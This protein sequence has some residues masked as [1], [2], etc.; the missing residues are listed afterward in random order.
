MEL[1]D[2]LSVLGVDALVHDGQFVHGVAS[3]CINSRGIPLRFR[4]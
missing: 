2:I 4:A 1:R 3:G